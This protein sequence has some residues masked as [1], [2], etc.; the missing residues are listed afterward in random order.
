MEKIYL[1]KRVLGLVSI[2]LG[3]VGLLSSCGSY[4]N[5]S[6]YDNDG[7]YNSNPEPMYSNRVKVG[8]TQYTDPQH[9]YNKYENYFSEGKN[10][11]SL[12]TDTDNYTT[13]ESVAVY[14]NNGYVDYNQNQT[15]AERYGS[16]GQ[17]PTSVS[18]N[19]YSDYGMGYNPYWGGY[20]GGYWGWRRPYV[21]LYWGNPYYYGGWN[22][23]WYGGGYYGPSWGWGYGP[24]YYGGGYYGGGYYAPYRPVVRGQGQ[25]TGVVRNNTIG[26]NVPN[27]RVGVI[28]NTNGTTGTL[29]RPGTGTNTSGRV[30]TVRENGV[31]RQ[32]VL[33]DPSNINRA[34]IQNN[35]STIRNNS[36]G[37]INRGTNNTNSIQRTPSNNSYNRSSSTPSRTYSPAS[38]PSRSSN[39]GGGVSRGGSSSGGG[40]SRS[41]GVRR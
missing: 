35:T 41:S 20:Y 23:G 28:R 9:T 12:I 4:Q 33:R 11:Y 24:G 13:E 34:S 15:Y 10:D 18:V 17:N 6:Y 31:S 7:I 1:N 37:I 30:T 32:A 21:G 16:F 19:I 2:L 27:N 40:T 39:F 14:N 36:N 29:N 3:S 8:S 5:N 25:R 26:S 22:S 38:T